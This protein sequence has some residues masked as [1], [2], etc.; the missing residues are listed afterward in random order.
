VACIALPLSGAEADA[1][2]A[3]FGRSSNSLVNAGLLLLAMAIVGLPLLF[4]LLVRTPYNT[5]VAE[6][7]P[8]PVLFDHRHHVGDDGIDCRYCHFHVEA[9]PYAG[10]PGPALC[11]NCHSQIWNDSPLLQPVR[12]AVFNDRPLA[13]NRVTALPGFVY[14]NHAIHVER[15]VGCVSCHGRLEAMPVVRKAFAMNMAWCLVCHRDPS[16]RL[17][18]QGEITSADWTAD[19]PQKLGQ[20]LAA[21]LNIAPPTT[22]TGCHR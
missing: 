2:M 3:L 16:A 9:G 17:R 22:C 10:V 8:Q 7:R 19:D 11:M 21:E 20:R 4:M 18:P 14:F 13:W 5:G 12:D 6:E 15:G 1:R